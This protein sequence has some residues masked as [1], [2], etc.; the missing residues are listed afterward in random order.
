MWRSRPIAKEKDA[1]DL[2]QIVAQYTMRDGNEAGAEDRA[3]REYV[4]TAQVKAAAHHYRRAADAQAAHRDDTAAQHLAAYR[5]HAQKLGIDPAGRPPAEVLLA[6]RES[7]LRE[8][9]PGFRPHAADIFA[10]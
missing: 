2:D 8:K 3:Y 6:V 7:Q 4:R 9:G 10:S 5:A 1:K